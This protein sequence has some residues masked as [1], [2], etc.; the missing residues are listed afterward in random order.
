MDLLARLAKLHSETA[1]AAQEALAEVARG[2]IDQ[3]AA[4][5]RARSACVERAVS[6]DIARI[7]RGE[8]PVFLIGYWNLPFRSRPVPPIRMPAAI[9]SGASGCGGRPN[10]PTPAITGVGVRANTFEV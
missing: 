5:R 6:R 3:R 4:K 10:F 2:A 9:G 1:P 8:W 7:W